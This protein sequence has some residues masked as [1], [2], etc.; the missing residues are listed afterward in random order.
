MASIWQVNTV[1]KIDCT[2]HTNW[3]GLHLPMMPAA[4]AT[5][6]KGL[7]WAH[8]ASA[9]RSTISSTIRSDRGSTLKWPSL[10]VLFSHFPVRMF[11]MFKKNSNP[12]NN[13]ASM[14]VSNNK[15]E[16]KRKTGDK[17][18]EEKRQEPFYRKGSRQEQKQTQRGKR[19]RHLVIK[20]FGPMHFFCSDNVAMP[21]SKVSPWHFKQKTHPAVAP[22]NMQ[23]PKESK[24]LTSSW[25]IGQSPKVESTPGL[26]RHLD[27]PWLLWYN[28]T[29]RK[30]R[31]SLEKK[32][33]TAP[34][35]WNLHVGGAACLPFFVEGA[36]FVGLAQPWRSK[37]QLNGCGKEPIHPPQRLQ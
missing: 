11:S 1:W 22:N 4:L 30:S 33:S 16:E 10:P 32:P 24:P 20:S 23:R 14:I 27:S 7:Q 3:F 21:M 5:P 13:R 18:N 2:N 28:P 36:E 34:P 31:N 17:E 35:R 8:I 9:S 15:E 6:L 25:L 26:F 12:F 29:S 37:G 19:A